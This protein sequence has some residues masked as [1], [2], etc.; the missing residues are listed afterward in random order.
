MKTLLWR[1]VMLATLATFV[2]AAGAPN[3]YGG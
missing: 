3:N 2:L 1:L